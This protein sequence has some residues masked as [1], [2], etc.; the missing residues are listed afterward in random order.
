VIYN[1]QNL[2]DE[3]ANW[4]HEGRVATFWWRDDD[5]CSAT[6]ELETLLQISEEF[7]VPV[8]LAVIPGKLQVG[9]RKRID[10]T[11][12]ISVLQHGYRHK[13]HAP[14]AE[15]KSEYGAHRSVTEM[16]RELQ[17]GRE[18]LQ[19][20][21]K[22]QFYPVL[23]PPWNRF[24]VSLVSSLPDLGYTGMSAMW[25]RQ[26]SDQGVD[27]T[28]V[29][30]PGPL[31]E[32]TEG[33]MLQVNTHINPVAW[34]NDQGFIGE[35]EALEQMV[36]HLRLRREYPLLDEPTGLLSHHLVQNESTWDFCRQFA[37]RISNDNICHWL[38][39]GDIWL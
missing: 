10:N 27:Q 18:L 32:Q 22:D 30:S 34:L 29:Y 31:V 35:N 3:L 37:E 21:F 25:A 16:L 5:A 1:W 7:R 38:G 6:P 36:C 11:S 8:S 23:V 33:Q 28:K 26:A 13:N 9:L 39:A 15:E 12:L 17:Q 20:E 4:S 14:V 24:A 19:S 2:T